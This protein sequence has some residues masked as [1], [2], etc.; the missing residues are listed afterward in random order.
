MGGSVSSVI[1]VEAARLKLKVQ[2]VDC[3][4]VNVQKAAVSEE[5]CLSFF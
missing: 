5:S 4:W 2:L 1:A 3:S